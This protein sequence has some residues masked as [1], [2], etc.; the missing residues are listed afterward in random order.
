MAC[1]KVCKQGS[2][3]A[4]KQR[5]KYWQSSNNALKQRSKYWQSHPYIFF[6]LQL[7]SMHEN[8]ICVHLC[9]YQSCEWVFESYTMTGLQPTQAQCAGNW[10]WVGCK[11]VIQEVCKNS[12]TLTASSMLAIKLLGSYLI[13]TYLQGTHT[14]KAV[15]VLLDHI[16]LNS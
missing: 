9:S 12:T 13:A 8:W 11:V 4:L 14:Y 10:A 7:D 2:N 1:Q 5:S 16:S 3:D 15:A 6:T